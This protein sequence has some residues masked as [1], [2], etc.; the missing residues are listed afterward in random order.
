MIA[1]AKEA[2][3]DAVVFTDHNRLAPPAH[4]EELNRKH[5][6]FRIFTGI[7]VDASGEHIIVV[8]LADGALEK[9][10][11]EYRELHGFVRKRGGFLFLAHPFRYGPA[12]SID[13]ARYPPDAAERNS[14]NMGGCDKAALEEFFKTYHLPALTNSDAHHK[15]Y[16][17]VYHNVLDRPARTS[18]ELVEILREGAFTCC[19]ME[20]RIAAVN[21][22]GEKTLR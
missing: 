1:A 7:E 5:A 17:G 2:G 18:A 14:A 20:E 11:W 3:L 22:S 10:G 12:V 16:V 15:D 4:L 21:A 13:I 19:R 9:G 6:P 8:G